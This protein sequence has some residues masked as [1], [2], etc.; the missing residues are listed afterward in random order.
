MP[1][2]SEETLKEHDKH[3]DFCKGWKSEDRKAEN[4]T[5]SPK[6]VFANQPSLQKTGKE[7]WNSSGRL[8][9]HILKQC[10]KQ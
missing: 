10:K 8:P 7:I 6:S 9:F 3:C 2:T 1:K 4:I 5:S